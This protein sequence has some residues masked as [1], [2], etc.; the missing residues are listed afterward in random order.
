MRSPER[1]S[2]LVA[3]FR[4]IL[5]I[6]FNFSRRHVYAAGHALPNY[7]LYQQSLP[8]TRFKNFRIHAFYLKLITQLIR[9]E[10]VSPC[11][12]RNTE[13][14]CASD[15]N[16]CRPRT[17]ASEIT[18]NAPLRDPW[19]IRAGTS[20]QNQLY[21]C[22]G[23]GEGMRQ[24]RTNAMASQQRQPLRLLRLDCRNSFWRNAMTLTTH[25][26]EHRIKAS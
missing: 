18:R 12:R 26:K 11:Q 9:A 7:L 6:F 13:R 3:Q 1:L 8:Q 22:A 20:V 17:R 4:P 24:A 14:T 21:G 15:P 25:I 10:L 19:S 16:N 2:G 5:N 23:A